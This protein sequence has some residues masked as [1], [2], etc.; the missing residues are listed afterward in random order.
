MMSRLKSLANTLHELREEMSKE[1]G[2]L[3]KMVGTGAVIGTASI[4]GLDKAKQTSK[5]FA[6]V[7]RPNISGDE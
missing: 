5:Q 6:A 1:A 3:A 2:P 7:N 4:A